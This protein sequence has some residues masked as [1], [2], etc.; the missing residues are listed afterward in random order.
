MDNEATPVGLDAQCR[1]LWI[2][3]THALNR[4]DTDNATKMLALNIRQQLRLESEN[5]RLR[6]ALLSDQ[7]DVGRYLEN[8]IR[9][10]G[11]PTDIYPDWVYEARDAIKCRDE[12]IP[13][14]NLLLD[15]L[16]WNVGTI[17]AALNCVK[18]LVAVEK[19]REKSR[20]AK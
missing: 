13:W 16:E 20:G 2:D 12:N 7:V 17:H 1:V 14:L 9:G 11:N 4:G 6:L 3:A 5:A 8:G 10:K 18:R 19:E 15:A